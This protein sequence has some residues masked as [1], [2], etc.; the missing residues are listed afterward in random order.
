MPR[1][2]E[3]ETD[4]G[5]CVQTLPRYREQ[6]RVCSVT[7]AAGQSLR[8]QRYSSEQHVESAGTSLSVVPRAEVECV[9]LTWYA[10]QVGHIDRHSAAVLARYV[11]AGLL[12]LDGTIPFGATNK[13]KIPIYVHVYGPLTC[14]YIRIIVTNRLRFMSYGG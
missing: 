5:H 8:Q 4:V 11:D 3:C 9:S 1:P 13:Y 12:E 6:W 10:L 2:A 14:E 7:S